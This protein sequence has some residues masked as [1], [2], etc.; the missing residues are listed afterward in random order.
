MQK[1]VLENRKKVNKKRKWKKQELK[2]VR[3]SEK[4]SNDFE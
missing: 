4:I 2:Y 1:R 3:K